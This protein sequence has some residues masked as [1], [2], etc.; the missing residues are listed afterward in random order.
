MTHTVT[1]LCGTMSL[2]LGHQRTLNCTLL[3]GAKM[4]YRSPPPEPHHVVWN[5]SEKPSRFSRTSL[6]W[7]KSLRA[8]H[9]RQQSF[10]SR[11]RRRDFS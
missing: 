4:V 8:E 9:H 5:S 1:T 3:V 7:E 10:S 11:F 2:P 6:I